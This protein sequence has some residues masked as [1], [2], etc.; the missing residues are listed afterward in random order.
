MEAALILA[1]IQIEEGPKIFQFMQ[2]L[3]QDRDRT[4]FMEK[5]PQTLAECFDTAHKLIQVRGRS[6]PAKR[7]NRLEGK[8]KQDAWK[9]GRCLGCG[10]TDHFIKDCKSLKKTLKTLQKALNLQSQRSPSP[11][12]KKKGKVRFNVLQGAATNE[13][14]P[15]TPEDGDSE[16][17]SAEP[18]ADTEGDFTEDDDSSTEE[19]SN[20]DPGV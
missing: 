13:D 15:A 5:D 12:P 10:A 4:F 9:E 2:G 1:D 8:A 19:S 7:T 6:K 16:Y 3:T 11:G 18:G 20:D 14:A 17:F